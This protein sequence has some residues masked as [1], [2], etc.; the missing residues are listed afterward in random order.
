MRFKTLL[1]SL[2]LAAA[3]PAAAFAQPHCHGPAGFGRTMPMPMMMLLRHVNLSAAQQTQVQQLMEANSTQAQP[4]MTQLHS[5]HDQI[6]DKLLSSGSVTATD[7]AP[8][9]QQ[10]SQVHQQLD[11]DMLATALKIR[12]VLT[13]AQLAQA[14]ELHGKFKSLRAQFQ[15][16]MGD[17]PPPPPEGAPQ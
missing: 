8:L 4:L 13:P 1:L 6:A 10:A 14:S 7:I 16:L 17:E 2:C 11:Q 5:I 3:I 15:T 12:A 9:Q